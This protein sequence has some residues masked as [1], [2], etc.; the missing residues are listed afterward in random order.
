[1]AFTFNLVDSALGSESPKINMFDPSGGVNQQQGG[2]QQ[3]NDAIQTSSS[4]GGS[5][6]GASGSSAPASSA[7]KQQR[8]AS[9]YNPSSAQAA[10]RGVGP[11]DSTSQ[12]TRIS[13]DIAG[14]NDKLQQQANEYTQK[15]ED[16]AA[17]YRVDSGD[18]EKAASGD[19]KSFQTV[20]SRLAK[21]A[22]DQFESFKGLDDKDLPS[23]ADNL[24]QQETYGEIYRKTA[25]SDYGT[26][27]SRF[28]SIL[29]A[30]DPRFRGEAASLVGSQKNLINENDSLVKNKTKDTQDMLNKAYETETGKARETLGGMST[31]IVT[32]AEEAAAKETAARAGLDPK[33]LTAQ[34]IKKIALKL[35]EELKGTGTLLERS[36]GYLDDPSAFDLTP[37]LNIDKEV[38]ADEF[39]TQADV[40]RFNRING[41]LGSGEMKTFNSQ[42]AGPQYSF[43]SQ[44]AESALKALLEGKRFAAEK[45]FDS[46]MSEIEKAA[47]ARAS[48]DRGDPLESVKEYLTNRYLNQNEGQSEQEI[49][50]EQEALRQIL[51]GE[52]NWR[53]YYEQ[54]GAIP[55]AGTPNRT[56]QDMLSPREAEEMN[57]LAQELGLDPI[58]QAG[59]NYNDTNFNRGY[60]DDSFQRS[61]ERIMAELGAG[62][63]TSYGEGNQRYTAVNDL[64]AKQREALKGVRGGQSVATPNRIK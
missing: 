6:S 61:F 16:T 2:G 9:S 64:L 45:G 15:A 33:T 54:Q 58:Y 11:V 24:K 50:A 60:F 28:Q 4:G 30:L 42:G 52:T 17:G 57:R 22:P 39:L 49:L 12:R 59:A 36:L 44:G 43:D 41:L 5:F 38:S 47:A 32:K 25:G 26:G 31:E 13:S 18:I 10:F 34:E 48:A 27:D 8:S 29:L 1:M 23:S 62:K 14:A 56:W 3:Q 37:Y 51:G 20:A 7:P 35:R 40:D 46:R 21:T 55:G 53:P 19:Q 63:P